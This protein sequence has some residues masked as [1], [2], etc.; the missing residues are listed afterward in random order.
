[1][2]TVFLQKAEGRKCV[3][4]FMNPKTKHQEKYHAK[5]QRYHD[6]QRDYR[7]TGD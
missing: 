3:I 5:S 1:M 2:K 4:V 6:T 7:F